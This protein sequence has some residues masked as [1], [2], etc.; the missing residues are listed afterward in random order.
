MPTQT[1]ILMLNFCSGKIFWSYVMKMMMII[2][3]FSMEKYH[4]FDSE[5]QKKM[6]NEIG[7]VVGETWSIEQESTLTLDK[8]AEWDSDGGS[9]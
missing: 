6:W 1:L 7:S 8:L 9:L 4:Q 2:I 5:E 3:H